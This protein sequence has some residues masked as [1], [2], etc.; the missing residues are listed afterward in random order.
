M[1][2]N[3]N[4]IMFKEM[5]LHHIHHFFVHHNGYSTLCWVCL[6]VCICEY[7]YKCLYV[8]VV[9]LGADRLI[10]LCEG[11]TTHSDLVWLTC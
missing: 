6:C 8:Y 10:I 1:L 2:F 7:V 4:L 5:L 11:I 9:W 3:Y